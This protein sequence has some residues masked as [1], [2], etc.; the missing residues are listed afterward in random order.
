M[1]QKFQIR[2]KMSKIPIKTQ[3]ILDPNA[4]VILQSLLF[5]NCAISEYRNVKSGIIFSKEET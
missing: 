2:S 4:I 1:G 5:V 3:D